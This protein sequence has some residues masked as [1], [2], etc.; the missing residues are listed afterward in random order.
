MWSILTHAAL[1][2]FISAEAADMID[3]LESFALASVAN[4][5]PEEVNGTVQ[6]LF[7]HKRS[8]NV[9]MYVE[10]RSVEGLRRERMAPLPSDRHRKLDSIQGERGGRE[11]ERA[12]ERK[13]KG[14]NRNWEREGGEVR[15]GIEV[16]KVEGNKRQ[17]RELIGP[18][19]HF[20][21]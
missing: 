3:R 11:A 20:P 15:E 7:V 16:E 9:E 19:L 10:E 14:R 8:T 6:D 21:I 18:P 17:M 1:P 12:G 4:L 5:V 13:R 2:Y